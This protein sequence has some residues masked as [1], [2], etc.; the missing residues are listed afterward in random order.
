VD[1]QF[2]TIKSNGE[3]KSAKAAVE[4][5]KLDMTFSFIFIAALIRNTVIKKKKKVS[6]IPK[7]YRP[8]K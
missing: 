4:D 8:C 6:S 1:Q 5:Y 2:I 7:F 3:D